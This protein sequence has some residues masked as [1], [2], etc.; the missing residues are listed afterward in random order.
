MV[1]KNQIKFI[2]NLQQKKYRNQHGLFVAEGVKLVDELISCGLAAVGI[3]ATE[4]DILQAKGVE[5]QKVSDTVLKR[6]SGLKT[7]N[8]VLAVFEIPESKP[9]DYSD[10]I[11]ALDDIKDPGNLG[12]IIRMCD[13]FGIPHMLCSPQTVDCYN[14]KTL[15]ASMGSV[16]RVNIVYTPLPKAIELSD[17]PAVGA[18]MDGDSVYDAAFN[19][20]GILVMGNESH[21]I[22]GEVGDLLQQRIGI[23][24]FKDSNVESLNVA[25]ATAILLS[26]VRRS[27][28]RR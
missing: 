27:S 22:S 1:V 19:G 13:W 21:G 24:R 10:W 7:P 26:E 28:I 20:A 23:P 17:L 16:G 6:M 2:K 3:Y 14:P 18:F 11:L 9:L 8:R 15:Q 5:Y 25:T 12:T 4:N